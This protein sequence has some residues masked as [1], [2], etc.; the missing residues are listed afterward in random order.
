MEI[1]S[2]FSFLT[3]LKQY[4]NGFSSATKLVKNRQIS[5]HND[6]SLIFVHFHL[7]SRIKWHLFHFNF[8]AKFDK[9]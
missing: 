6:K 4:F 5:I 7:M 1:T 9:Q 3:P 2:E 8:S